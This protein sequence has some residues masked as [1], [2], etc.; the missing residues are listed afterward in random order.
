MHEL[1]VDDPAS[2]GEPRGRVTFEP[3][4]IGFDDRVL[5]PRPWTIAQARWAREMLQSLSVGDVLELCSGAG[6]IGLAAVHGTGR[7]LVQVD[8]DEHACE[9]ARANA[10]T[11]GVD[12]D[13]R[14]GP[15]TRALDDD[16]LFAVVIADPPWVPTAG[17]TAFPDDPVW[18]I[19]GG[20]DG[21]DLAREC[22]QV[23][24]RHLTPDGVLVLQ[25]GSVEQCAK[26][27]TTVQAC[28]LVTAETRTLDGGAL[29]LLCRR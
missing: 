26:L 17:V 25:L 13:V 8:Q 21:L 6:H 11:A 15:M 22:V 2:A 27:E 1:D 24:G 12:S 20:D 3:V 7:R 29:A 14:C 28:G 18:A 4:D 5:V 19:D 9:L 10:R 23:A 16:E